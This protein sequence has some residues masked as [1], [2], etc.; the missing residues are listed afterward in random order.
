MILCLAGVSRTRVFGEHGAYVL[1]WRSLYQILC[2][3]GVLRNAV[4]GGFVE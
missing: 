4:F 2:L 1:V 3:A